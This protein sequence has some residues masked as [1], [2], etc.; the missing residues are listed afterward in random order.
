MN[1]D[2]N[3]S[4]GPGALPASVLRQT[5]DAIESL[6]ETGISLLG[7][8]HRSDWFRAMMD[9][10]E[11]NLRELLG[12]PDNYHVLFLQ[13]GSSLQ[14]TML[15][16]NFLRGGARR[17]EYIV[18][19]YWS[20]KAPVEARHE[21]SVR[22]V[23]DGQLEGYTRLPEVDSLSLSPS[24]AYLHY[25]SN[26]TVEG[27]EFRTVPGLPDVPL[28]CDMSSDLMA[29][30]IDV[31][32]YAMIYAHAQ[33]NLGP[34]GVTL[35][36]VRDDFARRGAQSLPT[37]LD[38]RTHIEARSLY[39]TPPV[40]AIYVMLLV[41]RWMR[42]EIG[43]LEAMALINQA[44]SDR[45][46]GVLDAAADFYHVHAARPWRSTMNVAFHLP[47]AALETQFLAAA[48]QEG[49]QG[50]EGHRS[51]GGV[52]ASLYNAVSPP[53]IETLCAWLADFADRHG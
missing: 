20:A 21:G 40:F 30:P 36:I 38:Y 26:E 5:R 32:R 18:S 7:M 53:A 4:G 35:V 17:A 37:L 46:Y 19:G 48:R 24:A 22:V 28:V 11:H 52:R 8:S 43:G 15:P 3:F 42:D 41:T 39:N 6:P 10:T 12:I 23:W 13:G 51:L 50:L 16:M 44:K 47:D 31:E 49:F 25:V 14:F 9:E 29:L 33:K 1:N 45:L 2:L 27:L 34:A